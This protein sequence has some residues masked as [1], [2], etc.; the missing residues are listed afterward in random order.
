VSVLGIS[1]ASNIPT[2]IDV[3]EVLSPPVGG[4]SVELHHDDLEL[5]DE[6]RYEQALREAGTT[7]ALRG[8][9]TA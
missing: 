1:V 5:S 3:K 6:S 7:D 9:D 4:S 8:A 2:R